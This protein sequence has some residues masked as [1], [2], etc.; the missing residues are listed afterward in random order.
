MPFYVFAW[1]STISFG[2]EAIFA[3]LTVC[4]NVKNPWLFNFVW[5]GFILL[6]SLPFAYFSGIGVPAEWTNIII[7]SVLYALANIT[8][9]LM[10][11]YFDVSVISPIYN[12]RIALTALFAIPLLGEIL[13]TYQYIL[14]GITFFA[15][16]LSNI[17]ESFKMKSV[18]RPVFILALFAV[19]F[20]ALWG[21]F[22]RRSIQT[23]GFWETTIYMMIIAQILFLL[24]IPFFR[25]DISKT[26][27]KQIGSLLL[28]SIFGTVGTLTANRAFA[29]NATISSV[30]LS[31]P[32]SMVLAFG[33]SV[34]APK[35]L[36]K[37]TL[38]VYAIRFGAVAVMIWAGLKLSS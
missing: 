1:V 22:V 14:I 13:S 11:Y 15:G 3:K 31:I 8:F 24:T 29:G 20:N 25:K 6:L 2:F 5:S 10:F 17:D 23:N 9:T 33:F 36:E 28:L 18:L 34:L 37:H 26:G 7:V 21:I 32:F 27:K 19:S 35:L 4:Y 16:I 38:R 12:M 30:I